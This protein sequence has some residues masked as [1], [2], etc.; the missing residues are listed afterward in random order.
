[1]TIEMGDVEGGT[2]LL[3]TPE[4]PSSGLLDVSP[5]DDNYSSSKQKGVS[6][7]YLTRHSTDALR[8]YALLLLV[9]T[10]VACPFLAIEWCILTLVFSSCAFG[11]I[12]S[13]WLSRS[14][15]QSDDGTPEMRE[16][17]DPIREGAEGFLKVQYTAIAKFAIPLAFLIVVSY[18]FRPHSQKPGGV[19][20]L[21]NTVLGI[22]AALGFC[23]GAV[24][25]AIAG[26]VSMWVATLS[27]IR[28]ASAARRS[29]GEALVLCFR[30]GAFSAVLN[31]TLCIAGTLTLKFTLCIAT[32]YTHCLHRCHVPVH[33]I[34]LYVCS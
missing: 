34:A 23:F 7:A 8:M 28:V 20:L 12:A 27:N 13:L 6:H 32:K 2:P 5:R 22:V 25:S 17:S 9:A 29:Y 10:C 31:L 16:V 19:A 3:R 14:V 24:C 11:A 15:L 1:M 26:Y 4:A 33:S 30:G 21:G 18:Q